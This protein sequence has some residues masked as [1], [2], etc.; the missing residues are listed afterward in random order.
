MLISEYILQS[1]KQFIIYF[2]S[3]FSGSPEPLVSTSFGN[4]LTNPSLDDSVDVKAEGPGT[5]FS[6]CAYQ[7]QV[8][9]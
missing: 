5:Y 4:V 9:F 6:D 1:H 3:D 2:S 7:T 8:K